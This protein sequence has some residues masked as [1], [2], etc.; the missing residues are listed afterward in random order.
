MG[1]GTL[2][3]RTG[4]VAFSWLDPTLLRHSSR[5]VGGGIAAGKGPP[6]MALTLVRAAGQ[7]AGTGFSMGVFLGTYSLCNQLEA[8]SIPFHHPQLLS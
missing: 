1:M 7:E 2:F 6:I 4:V 5:R 8:H 3:V